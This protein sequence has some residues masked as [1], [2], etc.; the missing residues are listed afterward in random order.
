MWLFQTTVTVVSWLGPYYAARALN[1]RGFVG[2]AAAT[3]LGYAA[4]AA[5]ATVALWMIAD[6]R[7]VPQTAAKELAMTILAVMFVPPFAI[8]RGW[9]STAASS[10]PSLDARPRPPVDNLAERLPDGGTRF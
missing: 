7:V 10:Q 6:M 4:I 3:L 8:W 5:G 1:Q 2:L 9:K